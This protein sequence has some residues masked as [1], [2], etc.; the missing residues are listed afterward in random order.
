MFIPLGNL[1]VLHTLNSMD[2]GF[3]QPVFLNEAARLIKYK[4]LYRAGN[5]KKKGKKALPFI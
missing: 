1:V 2:M 3:F 4:L 5:K